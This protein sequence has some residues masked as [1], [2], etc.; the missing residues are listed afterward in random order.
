MRA[1]AGLGNPGETRDS[2]RK[3]QFFETNRS[4]LRA[5]PPS[6]VGLAAIA[7]AKDLDGLALLVEADPVV[8]DAE[9]ILGRIDT[10]EPF[11]VAHAGIGQAFD[12]LLVPAGNALIECGHVLQCRPGPLDL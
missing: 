12:R 1:G 11:H 5:G 9:A 4:P 2:N 8:A 7:D 10:L 3:P 6:A